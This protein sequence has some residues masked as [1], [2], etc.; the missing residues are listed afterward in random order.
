MMRSRFYW[1]LMVNIEVTIPSEFM[2]EITGNLSSRRGRVQGMDS[3]GDF[4][5]VTGKYSYG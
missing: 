1:N 5:V 2:G 4:Q 3:F